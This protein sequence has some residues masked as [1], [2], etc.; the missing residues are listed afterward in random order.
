MEVEYIRDGK[1]IIINL[2]YFFLDSKKKSEEKRKK[3]GRDN[4]QG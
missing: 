2:R 1:R 4:N 3:E